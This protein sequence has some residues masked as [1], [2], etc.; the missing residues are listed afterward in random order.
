[1]MNTELFTHALGQ[2]VSQVQQIKMLVPDISPPDLGLKINSKLDTISELVDT[3]ADA[4][5]E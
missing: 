3:I 2:I 1:M 5:E 4:I